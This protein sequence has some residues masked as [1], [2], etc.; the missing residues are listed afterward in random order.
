VTGSPVERADSAPGRLCI[1]HDRCKGCALCTAACPRGLLVVSEQ[2]N[3]HGYQTAEIG[4]AELA[5]CTSCA[6]C[7]QVCPDLAIAVFRPLSKKGGG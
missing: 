2:P 6:L 7:A 4:S 1:D 5:R 3:R